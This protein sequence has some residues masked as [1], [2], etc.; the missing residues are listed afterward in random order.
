MRLVFSFLVT[1][2]ALLGCAATPPPSAPLPVSSITI[3]TALGPVKFR[4]EVAADDV[5]R[6]YGLMNRKYMRPNDGMLFDFQQ[7]SQVSFWMKDTILPLDM[8]FVRADGTIANIK[9]DARPFSLL[10][11][12]AAEP[13]R[14]VIEINGGRA[15]ALGIEAGQTV[16]NPIFHNAR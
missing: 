13:V 5:S 4:V 1:A 11:I 15:K 8:L 10:P 2:V 16:H 12:P 14:A 7:P 3:D 6:D 9:H